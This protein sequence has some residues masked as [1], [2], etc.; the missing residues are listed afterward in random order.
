LSDVCDGVYTVILSE[1]IADGSRSPLRLLEREVT[2]AV[3]Y[4]PNFAAL[5]AEKDPLPTDCDQANRS[6]LDKLAEVHA[7][8]G[9]HRLGFGDI[10][11]SGRPDFTASKD[12]NE[13]GI[14]VKRLG[15]STGIRSDLYDERGGSVETGLFIGKAS[16]NGKL[17]KALS[18]GLKG[19][20]AEKALQLSKS[21]PQG[22]GIIWISLGRDY[23]PASKYETFGMPGYARGMRRTVEQ[24]LNEAMATPLLRFDDR[25]VDYRSTAFVILS[26]GADQDEKVGNWPQLG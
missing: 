18:H 19:A 11:F 9:L 13:Y 26:T 24:S 3:Q 10:V 5:V 21:R 7:I 22:N 23:I 16:S 12:G 2:L 20:I 4:C 8:V 6:V 1:F 14:E 15:P 17:P 25:E